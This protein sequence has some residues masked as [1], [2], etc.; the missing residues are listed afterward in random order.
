MRDLVGV[1]GV[2]ECRLELL[3]ARRDGEAP[4][5]EAER[6]ALRVRIAKLG[7]EADAEGARLPY[8][9]E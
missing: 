7:Q 9:D 8:A 4:S 3:G 5:I 1:R 6:E 2:L